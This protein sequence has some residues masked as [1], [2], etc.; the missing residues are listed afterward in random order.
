V[1]IQKGLTI[2]SPLPYETAIQVNKTFVL[3]NAVTV[4]LK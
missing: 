4:Y 2:I 3:P 1:S